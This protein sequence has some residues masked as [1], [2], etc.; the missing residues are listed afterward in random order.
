MFSQLAIKLP[1]ADFWVENNDAYKVVLGIVPRIILGSLC[2]YTVSQYHDIWAFHFWKKLT[3]N[4]FLWLRNNLSTITSQFID[5]LIFVTI[6]F[7]GSVPNN[8]LISMVI[9]QFL[10]KLLIAIVDTPIVYL[11]VFWLKRS[12]DD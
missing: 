6:A 9:G 8:I 1:A 3:K 2:S 12:K 4:K 11:L 10:I 5:T 7:Y